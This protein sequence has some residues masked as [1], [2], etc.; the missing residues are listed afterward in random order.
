LCD[1]LLIIALRI[2]ELGA[3]EVPQDIVQPQA[4]L[5]EEPLVVDEGLLFE[6]LLGRRGK[7]GGM[8]VTTPH[9]VFVVAGWSS[10]YLSTYLL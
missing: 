8:H 1:E 5:M 2:V 10:S 7:E 4:M 6:L 9:A 3:T